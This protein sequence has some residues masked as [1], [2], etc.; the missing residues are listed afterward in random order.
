MKIFIKNLLEKYAP[1]L[2]YAITSYKH[3]HFWGK[4]YGR[5]QKQMRKKI[6]AEGEPSVLS[7]PFAGMRY[8]DGIVWGTIIPKW[9]GTY[10]C[11]LHSV[12]AKVLSEAKYETIID[13]GAAEGYYA[14][15]LAKHL[16]SIPVF[17]F[18]FDFRGR[19]QQRRLAKLN[20]VKNL[21]VGFRC[22]PIE[23]QQRTKKSSCLIICDIEG[24]EVQLLDLSKVP[25]LKGADIIVEI[26][27]AQGMS[28]S[29]V[30]DFLKSRFSDSHYI[31]IIDSRPRDAASFR[32]L[33][34]LK[35]T[36]EELL[37]A[38]DE[39]RNGLQCWLWMEHKP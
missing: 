26:H 14:V 28:T 35:V 3:R 6:F 25:A 18:D 19:C 9:L 23:L 32:D 24:F 8:I 12:I 37:M 4:R 7:G 13:V 16:P 36:D 1:R 21:I 20:N 39:G 2:R 29:G 38:L 15:G 31:E 5:F 30:R 34:P 33:L 27:P 22:D 17:T 10:E 11:E